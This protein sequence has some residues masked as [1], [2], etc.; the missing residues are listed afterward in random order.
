MSK[1]GPRDADV[2]VQ[3]DEWNRERYLRA[4]RSLTSS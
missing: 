2:K 3:V 4:I 1:R